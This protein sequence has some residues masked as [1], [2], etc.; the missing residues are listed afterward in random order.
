M[1]RS[2][3]WSTPGRSCERAGERAARVAEELA[4]GERLRDGGAVDRH[5]RRRARAAP[6]AW[7]ARATTSLPVPV[8]PSI[9]TG[10][11]VRAAVRTSSRTRSIAGLRADEP[12]ERS[13]SGRSAASARPR[14][15]ARRRRVDRSR[16]QIA[17]RRRARR[18]RRRPPSARRPPARRRRASP[19]TTTGTRAGERVAPLERRRRRGGAAD[20][21]RPRRAPPPSSSARS[22]AAARAGH[23]RRRAPA[24]PAPR[25]A[26]RRTVVVEHQDAHRRRSLRGARDVG[27]PPR[28]NDSESDYGARTQRGRRRSRPAP[29]P[30]RPVAPG[31]ARATARAPCPP[32]SAASVVSIFIAS[33]TTSGCAGL[34]RVAGRDQH[35]HDLPRHRRDAIPVPVAGVPAAGRLADLEDVR[36]AVEHDQHAL[37]RCAR[38]G[39]ARRTCASTA[40]S[41]SAAFS[42]PSAVRTRCSRDRPQARCAVDVSRCSRRVVL[43]ARPRSAAHRAAGG[44]PCSATQPPRPERVPRRRRCGAGPASPPEA[45][46]RESAIA[47]R[48]RPRRRPPSRR[49][50]HVAQCSSRKPGVRL[51]GSERGM[52]PGESFAI[53]GS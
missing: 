14:P 51:A 18:S 24:R 27:G 9:S 10:A 22:T 5:E 2:A 1:P 46:R 26:S 34:D 35:A 52:R 39:V 8:S 33:S 12:G 40:T 37:A 44:F 50:R 3:S 41:S 49:A 42:A 23:R 28:G 13:A 16:R 6:S 38:R 17:R 7:M 30:R 53:I 32:T 43:E 36:P 19:T 4:L 25:T 21:G 47:P 15:T 29:R 31:V 48:S 11:S 45:A 20:R